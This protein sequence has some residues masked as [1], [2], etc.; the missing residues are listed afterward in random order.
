MWWH[1]RLVKR[2]DMYPALC[3]S[4]CR[5]FVALL[6]SQKPWQVGKLSL[7]PKPK[8]CLLATINRE[9]FNF[10]ASGSKSHWDKT[11]FTVPTLH[12]NSQFQQ[13]ENV[14]SGYWRTNSLPVFLYLHPPPPYTHNTT[15]SPRTL[16]YHCQIH[17]MHAIA[18]H[19]GFRNAHHSVARKDDFFKEHML[20][21][22]M[23]RF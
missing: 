16:P 4:R 14:G 12:L 20:I 1:L 13:A 6:L 10:N 7:I 23:P 9:Y 11:F 5:K 19:G 18:M 8:N 2:Y 17:R 15:F 3:Y 22:Y 21:A